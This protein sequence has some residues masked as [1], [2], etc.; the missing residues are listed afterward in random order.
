MKDT[1]L[2]R[3]LANPRGPHKNARSIFTS[4]PARI[5]HLATFLRLL[6]LLLA[7]VTYRSLPAQIRTQIP[8]V[9]DTASLKRNQ[10]IFVNNTSTLL[11]AS[12]SRKLEAKN[13]KTF[14]DLTKSIYENKINDLSRN[15]V[16]QLKKA[17]IASLISNDDAV[18]KKLMS[19]DFSSVRT[20]AKFSLKE[21]S[22]LYPARDSLRLQKA[23][24]LKKTIGGLTNLERVNRNRL[25]SNSQNPQSIYPPASPS[26]Q[27][28]TMRFSTA[29]GGDCEE[30]SEGK[31]LFSPGV[32]VL[33]LL[34]FLQTSYVAD[35]NT[36]LKINKWFYLNIEN[37]STSQ[38]P[39]EQGSYVLYTNE[40]LLNA[41][42][43]KKGLVDFDNDKLTDPEINNLYNEFSTST[44]VA[45]PHRNVLV[46]LFDSYVKEFGTNRREAQLADRNNAFKAKFKEVKKLTDQDFA[47]IKIADDQIDYLKLKEIKFALKGFKE[48]EFKETVTQEYIAAIAEDSIKNF[49]KYYRKLLRA[50]AESVFID[51]V[52]R[53]NTLGSLSA[54]AFQDTLNHIHGWARQ[55]V[56]LHID[57]PSGN[58][59]DKYPI[60]PLKQM[61]ERY[62]S[63][64]PDYAAPGNKETY[65]A[66]RYQKVQR[67]IKDQY[68]AEQTGSS[69]LTPTQQATLNAKADIFTAERIISEEEFSSQFDSLAALIFV[70]LNTVNSSLNKGF[71]STYERR[72][73]EDWRTAMASAEAGF[74]QK[75]RDNLVLFAI[76]E[77]GIPETTL[78]E[79]SIKSLADSLYMDLTIDELHIT[80]PLSVMINRIHTFVQLN[81]FG[82]GPGNRTSFNEERWKWLQSYGIWHAAMMVTLYPENFLIQDLRQGATD[83]FKEL[84]DSLEEGVDLNNTLE[85]YQQKVTA[86]QSAGEFATVPLGDNVFVVR[87]GYEGVWY[88]VIGDSGS[89]RQWRM[90]ENF[91]PVGEFF[92][93][94]FVTGITL[95]GPRQER[96]YFIY[97]FAW[98][99]AGS[100]I[101]LSHRRIEAING[102]LQTEALEDWTALDDVVYRQ[103]QGGMT[104]VGSP[105]GANSAFHV[106]FSEPHGYEAQTATGYR[107][108][109]EITVG[110]AGEVTADQLSTLEQRFYLWMYYWTSWSVPV[111]TYTIWEY[112]NNIYKLGPKMDRRLPYFGNNPYTDPA[113]NKTS[114]ATFQNWI[115]Q[116]RLPITDH[117]RFSSNL[118]FRN[119]KGYDYYFYQLSNRKGRFQRTNGQ[120]TEIIGNDLDFTYVDVAIVKDDI[121][122]FHFKSKD[123]GFSRVRV[124]PDGTIQH[125]NSIYH[126]TP[127][128]SEQMCLTCDIPIRD[129]Y[130]ATPPQSLPRIY[131]DEYNLH[132]PL[133]VADHLNQNDKFQ[134]AYEWLSKI[135]DP[136]KP[137][138]P[139]RQIYP[140]FNEG[141]SSGQN[142]GVWFDDPFDPFAIADQHR[143]SYLVHVKTAHVKNMLDWAD[144]L[145]TQESSESINRARELYEMA[146]RILGMHHWPA[147]TCAVDSTRFS[148]SRP[149][150]PVANIV[151]EPQNVPVSAFFNRERVQLAAIIPALELAGNQSLAQ[152]FTSVNANPE[153]YVLTDPEDP[154]E[155]VDIGVEIP[156]I[157]EIKPFCLPGNPMIGLLKWR[158]SSNL[159]KIKTNR[160]FAGIQRTLMPYATPLDPAKL[161]KAAASGGIDF[162]QFIPSVPPPVYRYSFLVER[163]K[164]LVSI[165]QQY[166]SSMLTSLEKADQE[167][168]SYMKAKQDV[169]L[170]QGNV[171]LQGL[172]MKEAQD[173]KIM[174]KKQ[175]D[176]AQAQFDHFESLLDEGLLASEKISFALQL[177]AATAYGT[178]AGTAYA[179]PRASAADVASALGSSLQAFA[180]ASAT[181]ASWSRRKEDWEF[182][183]TL[184]EKDIELA[185]IGVTIADD[186]VVISNQESNI[187]QLR[188][189][190]AD[191][192]VEFLGNKFTGKELYEW[193]AKNL[194]KL[195]REQ[196]NMAI[197]TAKGAQRSLEFERQTSLDFIGSEYWD[198][199]KKGLLGAE[200][201]LRDVN[202]LDDYK[203]LTDKRKSE[204][205]KTI[206]MVNMAP[207][208]FVRFKRTGV[209]NFATMGAWFDRDFPGHYLRLIKNVNVSVIALIPP[210][211]GIHATLSNTGISHVMSGPP[212][213]EESVIYRLPES[214]ALSQA[215]NATGLF[216]LRPDDNLLLPFEGSGVDTQWALEMPKGANRFNFATIADILFTIRYTAFEDRSYRTSLLEA[217]GQDEYGNVK[218]TSKRHFS[219]A[220]EF[221]DQWYRLHNPFLTL[222]TIQYVD[223][224]SL[225]SREFAD[226]T[227]LLKGSTMVIDLNQND[228]LPNESNL[229]IKKVSIAVETAEGH[230][231]DDDDVLPFKVKFLPEN[232]FETSI[233]DYEIEDIFE[234]KLNFNGKRPYGKWVI[235]IDT[236]NRNNR[237]LFPTAAATIPDLSWLKDVVLAV[238]YSCDIHYNK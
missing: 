181:W 213:Q 160:N 97:F 175:V 182:Q 41:I 238:E 18:R 75:I 179:D 101:V 165:A 82:V 81:S 109:W 47:L 108:A 154:L 177:S 56:E 194:R 142:M 190:F 223:P 173:S 26:E 103:S 23:A 128:S 15:E 138:E 20:L 72:A 67:R 187:A 69:T 28:V 43:S 19:K 155:T 68:I 36:L 115:A 30:C 237:L 40:I 24:V 209:L 60:V 78:S 111:E 92:Q 46:T 163:S 116:Y 63:Y 95:E 120:R 162:D 96:K 73:E 27:Q 156:E 220:N 80:T 236:S 185:D 200:M 127:L 61:F 196:L 147:D 150:L 38:D 110:D 186:R 6:C 112:S 143:G 149:E 216:D 184:A 85:R 225:S 193:M 76:H 183:R 74:L 133:A 57:C 49:N 107:Y 93:F 59:Y 84:L 48:R 214:I 212:F 129:R 231:W 22:E 126:F 176:R 3:T 229:K 51:S 121:Y 157:L 31:N 224:F 37:V 45:F 83:D 217:L 130:A 141:G 79:G 29:Y 137:D 12:L 198:D 42:A 219:I 34:D 106:F 172:R 148:E 234:S 70:S 228:F 204:I 134:Q 166:Q 218:S 230:V 207:A 102:V 158:I 77:F 135:Y 14:E 90:I 122:L 1:A 171:I 11:A 159:L 33:Y 131:L 191:D 125:P 87:A 58:Q 195:Y 210:N 21:L 94:R 5:V 169:K 16:S 119:H 117:R 66:Q 140:A 89:P 206:S 114:D 98:R 197:A 201:L 118:K 25:I 53:N 235:Q 152:Y 100:N 123:F 221:P 54:E 55:C 161:V 227:K 167:N 145:F 10:K 226:N 164:Y 105:T 113:S 144:H 32:Y 71:V 233:I 180:A 215:A 208:E 203:I 2:S 8:K 4:I 232:G 202:K 170:E 104:Y 9:T 13:I 124:E 151:T 153:P 52:N 99:R 205:E 188:K 222:D 132:L 146:M 86:Y 136:K 91:G 88:T 7:L 174:A 50:E 192:A 189:T 44:A 65:A 211:E 17:T 168:Y 35:L 39:K 64:Y 199:E 139:S 62:A 178:G